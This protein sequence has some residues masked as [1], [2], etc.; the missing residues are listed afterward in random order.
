MLLILD[1]FLAASVLVSEI[2][3]GRAN[4]TIV[5][6]NSKMTTTNTVNTKKNLNEIA[7]LRYIDKEF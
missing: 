4:D 6:R 5:C 7:K 3:F 1:I 2:F